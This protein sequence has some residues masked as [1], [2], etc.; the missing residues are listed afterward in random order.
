MRGKQKE[1]TKT[2]EYKSY[3]HFQ[4]VGTMK[5]KHASKMLNYAVEGYRKKIQRY[6][7]TN[8]AECSIQIHKCNAAYNS[9]TAFIGS[10]PRMFRL[11]WPFT[12]LEYS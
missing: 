5:K 4:M 3:P 9:K 8:L 1:K 2:P 12:C 7:N 10:T 6:I 11:D